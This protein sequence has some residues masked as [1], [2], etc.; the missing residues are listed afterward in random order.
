MPSPPSSPKAER[1]QVSLFLDQIRSAHNV[2]AAFRLADAF[3]LAH[4]YCAGITPHPPHPQIRKTALGAEEA[5]PWSHIPQTPPFLEEKKQEH[6]T[7]I[8]IEQTP[9]ARPL[10]EK[11]KHLLQGR[12]IFIF[13]HELFGVSAD[14]LHMADHTFMIPQHGIK[15]SLN[16]STCIAIV[17]WELFR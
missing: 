2:G 6:H 12:C 9:A 8:A 15:K 4:I 1:P 5:V 11:P 16:V 10:H 3:R 13:G 14:A 7:L 17:L